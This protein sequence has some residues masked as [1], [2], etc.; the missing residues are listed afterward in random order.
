MNSTEKSSTL[1]AAAFKIIQSRFHALIKDMGVYDDAIQ[2]EKNSL[3]DLIATTATQCAE[4]IVAQKNKEEQMEIEALQVAVKEIEKVIAEE[5]DET[6]ATHND[7]AATLEEFHETVKATMY[8][9]NRDKNMQPH[10]LT[11]VIKD[12]KADCFHHIVRIVDNLHGQMVM[13][14]NGMIVHEVTGETTVQKVAKFCDIF[15]DGQKALTPHVPT[16]EIAVLRFSLILE[17]LIEF[18]EANNGAVLTD[19]IALL[20]TRTI[21]LEDSWDKADLFVKQTDMQEVL[22]A[23][24]DL[25]YVCDGALPFYGL[26]GLFMNAFNII[27]SNNMRKLVSTVEEAIE[28]VQWYREEYGVQ[29]GYTTITSGDDTFYRL[30]CIHDPSG[31]WNKGKVLKPRNYEKVDLSI[32]F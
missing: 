12:A 28:N 7:I 27:H 10:E 32:L 6:I 1:E 21:L 18:A 3:D 16:D 20:K 14:S 4:E 31:N 26:T 23:L 30:N 2:E 8:R 29:I 22:D 5:E 17:E 13:N 11:K 19:C 9:Y 24:V 15:N 25:R